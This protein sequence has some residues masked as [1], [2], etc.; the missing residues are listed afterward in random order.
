MNAIPVVLVRNEEYHIGQVLRPLAEVFGQVVLG[1]TG[2]T[3]RTVE[4]A[5]SVPTVEVIELGPLSPMQLGQARAMLGGRVAE[6]GAPW[7]F[8][9]DGDELYTAETLHW[10]AKQEPPLGKWAGF[11]SMCSVDLDGETGRLWELADVFSRLAILPAQ[12][13]WTGDYPFEV[14]EVFSNPANYW[15]VDPTPGWPFHGLHL[16]RLP[17]SS[18]DGT[19]FLR[20]QKQFQFAMQDRSVSRTQPLNEER[21]GLAGQMPWR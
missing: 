2:S 14:P 7:M 11:T 17:R 5:L 10:I 16:H 6:L 3:D 15:Y 21:W 8:Q 18:Q 4:I 9:V 12:V 19:V 13:K 1:D 20:R